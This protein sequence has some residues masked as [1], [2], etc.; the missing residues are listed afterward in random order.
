MFIAARI[1][2]NL[3]PKERHEHVAPSELIILENP[4]AINISSLRNRDPR[5]EQYLE[6]ADLSALFKLRLVEA[7]FCLILS[8][9]KAA[10]SRRT[11][12]RLIRLLRSAFPGSLH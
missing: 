10:T 3:A 11:A 8:Q 5:A 2:Q 7:F 9:V 1:V 4:M 12:K 6:C